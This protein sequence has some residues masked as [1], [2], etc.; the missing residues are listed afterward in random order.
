MAMRNYPGTDVG[1][2]DHT[3]A[4]LRAYNLQLSELRQRNSATCATGGAV[5]AG[6][7]EDGCNES[8]WSGATVQTV[9]LIAASN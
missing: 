6:R 8:R 5:A 3:D 7:R 4:R 1:I 2:I 9:P